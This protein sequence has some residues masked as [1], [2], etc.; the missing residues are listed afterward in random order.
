MIKYEF[1]K[2]AGRRSTWA[3]VLAISLIN[4]F[5]LWYLNI[6]KEGAPE[7]SAYRKLEADLSVQ[8]EEQKKEY[9]AGLWS[10]LEGVRFVQDILSIQDS[11][12]DIAKI[13]ME[14][15]L[16]NHPGV[17]ESYYGLYE[18][19]D[20]LVYTDSLEKELSL[21]QEA[22]EELEVVMG[23]S[24]YLSSIQKQKENLSGIS[25]FADHAEDKNSYSSRNITKS[26]ED[27]EGLSAD[28]VQFT[29]SKGMRL[30]TESRSS[31][32]LLILSVFLILGTLIMEEKEKGLFRITRAT[33]H[34]RSAII[35][36]LGALFV[37][38]MAMTCLIYG[39]NLIFAAG[40]T[41][42]GELSAPL[43]SYAPYQGS[44]LPL[45]GYTYLLLSIGTKGLLVFA[46]GA[47]LM[48]LAICFAGSFV[49]YLGGC[50]VLGIGYLCYLLIPAYSAWAP[51]KYLNPTALLETKNLYGAYLNLNCFGYPVSRTALSA[52]ALLLYMGAAVFAA[53]LS[54]QKCRNLTVK[55]VQIRFLVPFRPHGS[56]FRHEAYK[57]F[58]ANHALWVLLLAAGLLC[59][60]NLSREYHPSVKEQYYQSL[61]MELKGELTPEKER[62]LLSEQKRYETAFAKI[63]EIDEMVA[64]GELDK[65][66]GDS[67]KNPYYSQTAFY[68]MF[69]RAYRQYA[70]IL[71]EGGEFVYDTG[72]LY[73]F[74]TLENHFPVDLLL[75][76]LGM[77]LAFANTLPVEDSKRSWLFLSAT[78]TGKRRIIRMKLLIAA[79]TGAILALLPWI[80]RII[81]VAQVFPLLGWLNSVRMVEA[82]QDFP[83]MPLAVLLVFA[84][85]SQIG[86]VMIMVGAVFLISFWRKNALFTMFFGILIFVVP[87]VLLV[88]GIDFLKWFSLYPVYSWWCMI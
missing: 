31:D 2:I 3:A 88:L 35:S 43:P 55:H 51:L 12:S 26:A 11:S 9:L 15:E 6:P 23:Y 20:Y 73:L 77:I 39:S 64:N 18:S 75:I 61:M 16:V 25:I 34:G 70:L 49:P 81:R 36:K 24:D 85:L 68:P 27:F 41:G 4:L 28:N 32:V 60:Q 57:I 63:E 76:A 1:G 65:D 17:F 30:A 42:L 46:L 79:L 67:L 87:L 59:Y 69:C 71:E 84:V 44:V 22:C 29:L 62:L 5:L 50:S 7:L 38:C 78:Q 19:G 21:I 82:Y 66:I 52:A 40:T 47:F 58:I 72:Y 8:G 53:V 37:Y 14:Q 83:E 80:T 48:W 86:V 74:G 33:W 10:E 13:V 56:L 45:T 54:F